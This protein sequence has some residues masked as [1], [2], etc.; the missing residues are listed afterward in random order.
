YEAARAHLVT[1]NFKS[2]IDAEEFGRLAKEDVTEAMLKTGYPRQARRVVINSITMAMVSDCL[3]HIFE[4]LKCFEKRKIVVGFNLLRKPLK[5][6][7]L[8]LAWMV[9]DEG[10][11]FA[12]FMSG[13]P[14][15]LTQKKLGNRR[16]EIFAKAIA[17]M[18]VGAPFAPEVLEAL[19]YSRNSTFGFEKL[20]EHAVHLITVERIELRTEP[21]NFNFIFKNFSDDDSYDALYRWLPYIL[22]FVAHAMFVLFDRMRSMDKGTKTAFAVRSLFAYALMQGG[23]GGQLALKELNGML[24]GVICGHCKAALNITLYNAGKI[25]LA[26]SFRCAK[27][28]KVNPLPFSWA[29]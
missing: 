15:N 21:K 25:L 1:V 8:Y 19:I 24:H 12:E 10:E 4:A 27:C 11:F 22:L 18:P 23:Q 2:K 7:L 3:H 28:R 9:G 29:F 26:D 20:F 5:Q 17:K 6:N 14:E 16:Q 13:K